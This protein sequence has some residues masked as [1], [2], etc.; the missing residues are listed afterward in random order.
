MKSIKFLA[1]LA[2]PAMFAACTNDDLVAVQEDMQQN[3][4]LVGADLIGTGVSMKIGSG[5]ESRLSGSE[6]STTDKLGLGWIVAGSYNSAQTE[7][8]ELK[9][10]AL[11]ANHMFEC[12]G[13]NVFKTK[14]NL[15]KGWHFG[16]FPFEYMEEIG[17]VKK[18]EINPTQTEEWISDRYNTALYLSPREFLTA[19]D[20]DKD[21]QL[22]DHVVYQLYRSVN[23]IGVT[24]NPSTM[25]TGSDVLKDLAVKEIK[26]HAGQGIFYREA[27]VSPVNLSRIQYDEDGNYD[28]DKDKEEFFKAL[29]TAFD[30][31]DISAYKNI[32]T[33]VENS[34]INMSGAQTLRIHTLP[35]KKTLSA[36]NVQF[37]INVEGGEFTVGYATG[38]ELSA[39][40][41]HNNAAIEA[42]VEACAEEGALTVFPGI[43]LLDLQLTGDMFKADFTSIKSEE[44]WNKAVKIANALEME[45][46]EFT[47]AAADEEGNNWA[48][49]DVDGDGNLINLPEGD[50]TV[51]GEK[52]ILS[53]EGEWPTEGLTV[54]TD[55]DVNADLTVAG[56]MDVTKGNTITNKATIFAGAESSISTKD[57][58]ALDNA[59]GRVIVEYGAYVYPTLDKEGVIAYEVKNAKQ[60]TIQKINVLISEHSKGYASVN[61]LIVSTNL[62]LNAQA[63]DSDENGRYED[64]IPAAYLKNLESIAVEL[65]NKGKLT[66]EGENYKVKSVVGVSGKTAITNVEVV[67]EI[68]VLAGEMTATDVLFHENNNIYVAKGAILNIVN[69]VPESVTVKTIND[70]ILDG[71]V[72]MGLDVLYVDVLKVNAGS[73]IN[74]ADGCKVICSE[75]FVQ[76]GTTSGKVMGEAVKT[77][78]PTEISSIAVDSEGCVLI[79]SVEDLLAFANDPQ[80][81]INKSTALVKT[82]KLTKDLD[83]GKID[84]NP[85]NLWSSVKFILDG[86]NKTIKNLNVSGSGKLGFIGQ[87]GDTEITIKN[88]VFENPFVIGSGSF[89]GTV[90]GY[91][92]GKTILK[93]VDVKGGKV[94]TSIANK[95]IRVGGLIGFNAPDGKAFELDGCDVEGV[96]LSAYHNLGG[97][98]GSSLKV[99][100]VMKNCTSKNNTFFYG[101]NNENSWRAFDC[102]AFNE[103][104]STKTNC[105]ESGN[106]G[107][108]K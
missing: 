90:V 66:T 37:T 100:A 70:M 85:V 89:I 62:D 20:L 86:N 45:E 18:V 84:W 50:L 29:P 17:K 107:T 30:F 36:E 24:I 104:K 13:N 5:V 63:S 103:G 108:K 4:E 94:G 35:L 46:V 80:S 60:E 82:V 33:K 15:Y 88:L 21:Y 56:T 64:A 71:T 52:M 55:I 98:V 81:F 31:T 1:A 68:N 76:E 40:E 73:L 59:E 43:L 14:G 75:E 65:V 49:M 41:E 32:A 10:N 27:Y 77:V 34:G 54:D 12:I 101:A 87:T 25:F 39:E 38:D 44:E 28:S 26:L 78:T 67:N 74:I 7:N 79:N 6:W 69:S 93:N 61:T 9:D 53:A 99:G 57:N 95:G 23:T 11:Y 22:K 19:D 58:S 83:L 48:F 16:Y 3:V 47:I 102:D 8:G 97:L 42:F 72:N 96:T 51:K 92:Y 2:L 105:S 106:V 91:D